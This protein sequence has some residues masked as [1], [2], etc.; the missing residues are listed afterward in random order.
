MRLKRADPRS[1][2]SARRT[3]TNFLA[4]TSCRARCRA[5]AWAFPRPSAIASAKL[6]NNT[7]N[8]SQAAMARMKPGDSSPRPQSDWTQSAVVRMLPTYT[9]NITGLRSSFRG[10]SFR[11]ESTIARRTIFGS[12]RACA[13]AWDDM[14][15]SISYRPLDAECSC[16]ACIPATDW[17]AVTTATPT[18]FIVITIIKCSTIGPSANA[19]MNVS[20]PTKITVPTRN[21][22]NRGVCVGS[23]PAL[24]GVH[25]FLRQRPGDGQRGNGQPIAGHQHH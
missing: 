5:S 4:D 6:A 2:G 17:V 14:L 9:V 20:T 15:Y 24:V 11:N 23:V 19:G 21:T 13:F 1:S 10:S 7:V 25:F 22:T 8:Q 12:N 3:F 16:T 18:H